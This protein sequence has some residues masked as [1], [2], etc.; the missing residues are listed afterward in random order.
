MNSK[1]DIVHPHHY[2]CQ[3]PNEELR[4][5]VEKR[6]GE[7]I[8]TVELI[9]ATDAPREKEIISIV[10]LLDVDEESMLH[11]MGDVNKPEHHIIHCRENVKHMLGLD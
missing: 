9:R 3:I 1:T 7:Q 10:A 2:F 6:Y 4:P 5:W 8:P 11:M